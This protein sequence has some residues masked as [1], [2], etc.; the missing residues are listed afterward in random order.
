MNIKQLES[1][2]YKYP[3]W[4]L[5][6]GNL[7]SASTLFGIIGWPIYMIIVEVFIKKKVNK[8]IYPRKFIINLKLYFKSHLD[9]CL[10]QVR[11]GLL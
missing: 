10:N 5:V 7:I 11:I 1:S 4:T 2:D 8:E 9:L 3:Y 6:V